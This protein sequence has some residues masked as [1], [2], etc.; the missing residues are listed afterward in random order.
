MV[1]GVALGLQHDVESGPRAERRRR[2]PGIATTTTVVPGLVRDARSCAGGRAG[3]T[4]AASVFSGSA[5][6]D[7]GGMFSALGAIGNSPVVAPGQAAV[8]AA[9]VSAV[10]AAAAVAAGGAGPAASEAGR[11]RYTPGDGCCGHDGDF[12]EKLNAGDR[13]GAVALMDERTEM[14]VHVGDNVQTLRGIERVGGWFLR[15]D[16][17]PAR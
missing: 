1:W 15:G 3:A 17:G 12:F 11:P 14:R 6:P 8:A 7:F 13:E 9:A 16:R 5:V 2:A 4:V 10:E